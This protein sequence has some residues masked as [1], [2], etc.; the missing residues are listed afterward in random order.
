VIPAAFIIEWRAR[1]PWPES[2]QV[3]Q[4]LIDE[5]VLAERNA[6]HGRA[7]ELGQCDHPIHLE[8]LVAGADHHFAGAGNLG[9]GGVDRLDVRAGEQLGHGAAR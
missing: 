1:V 3:E 4:D 2:Y 9:V 6:A 7:V 8:A 5:A